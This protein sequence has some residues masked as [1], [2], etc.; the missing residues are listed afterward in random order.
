MSRSHHVTNKQLRKESK[1][2]AVLGDSAG[3]GLTELEEKDLKKD[4]TK[5]NTAWK[6]QAKRDS[7]RPGLK[8]RLK[9]SD[10]EVI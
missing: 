8:M 1:E 5:V 10:V 7:L 6:K 9:N 3:S 2:N 4:I